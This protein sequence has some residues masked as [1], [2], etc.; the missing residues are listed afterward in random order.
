MNNILS[1]TGDVLST[2]TAA[3]VVA[4]PMQRHNIIVD[5][6]ATSK[7]NERYDTLSIVP[8]EP[9][10]EFVSD[11]EFEG[12]G[13]DSI[14]II[15]SKY[16]SALHTSTDLVVYNPKMNDHDVFM[17]SVYPMFYRASMTSD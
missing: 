13:I 15:K 10:D 7:V 17:R 12:V 4:Q 11:D 3:S 2:K 6:D 5:I 8:M 14:V 1:E 9:S 16:L